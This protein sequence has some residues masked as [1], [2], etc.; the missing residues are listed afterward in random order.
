MTVA[1]APLLTFRLNRRSLV[2]PAIAL[3]GGAIAVVVVLTTDADP[4]PRAFAVFIPAIIRIV[5]IVTMTVTIDRTNVRATWGWLWTSDKT[6]P[7]ERVQDVEIQRSI[8][9]RLLGLTQVEVSSAGGSGSIKLSFFDGAG[10]EAFKAALSHAGLER[11][12]PVSPA[13]PGGYSPYA[14]GGHAIPVHDVTGGEIVRSVIGGVV[15]T[16]LLIVVGLVLAVFVNPVFILPAV[17]MALI[18]TGVAVSRAL[19]IGPG[20]STVGDGLLRVRQG[21][22]TLRTTSTPLPRIQIVSSAAGPSFQLF[23]FETVEYRSA[24]AQTAK[25][26]RVRSSLTPCIA[27]RSIHQFTAPLIGVRAPEDA[28]LHE[29]GPKALVSTVCRSVQTALFWALNIVAVAGLV[30]AVLGVVGS[31]SDHASVSEDAPAI[32]LGVG[33][34]VAV[35][36]LLVGV[37]CGLVGGFIR[38]ERTRF[39]VDADALEV[40][41]GIWTLRTKVVPLS[42]IQAVDVSRSP[43]QRICGTSSVEVDIAGLSGRWT[44]RVVD[45]LA[46]DAEALA[47]YLT[48]AAARSAL[49]DGV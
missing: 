45:V 2:L 24:D 29:L 34:V 5:Q 36:A 18:T 9:A 41:D 31:V 46:A 33:L 22:L 32:A 28:S 16:G 27:R 1:E 43:A 12:A 10:A 14:G 11:R 17:V 26:E 40:I 8:L 13:Y 30:A 23:G 20:E 19:T 48:A 37:V 6:I 42:K 44:V 7:L 21:V 49:P 4:D 3:L 38:R 15:L 39:G 47:R 25:S 35:L